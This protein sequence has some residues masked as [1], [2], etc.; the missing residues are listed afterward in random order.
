MSL[1]G[2][3]WRLGKL[4]GCMGEEA[5]MGTGLPLAHSEAGTIPLTLTL[6]GLVG[7]PAP[8]GLSPPI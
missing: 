8:L 7:F 2:I 5:A 6:W 1:V 3:R 4:E